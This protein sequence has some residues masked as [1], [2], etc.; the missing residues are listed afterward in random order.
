MVGFKPTLGHLPNPT[1]H[2]IHNATA[3]HTVASDSSMPCQKI[4]KK[5][6]QTLP[7][8]PL[9]PGYKLAAFNSV[10]DQMTLLKIDL[11]TGSSS[12]LLQL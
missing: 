2:L 9:V 6:L 8:D 12:G 1:H 11:L 5:F 4:F 3:F 10:P 7:D